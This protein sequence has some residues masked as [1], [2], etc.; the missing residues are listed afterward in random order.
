MASYLWIKYADYVYNKWERRIVW[1]M[2]KRY[3]RPK[4]FNPLL[5]IY[6]AAF[7]TGLMSAAITEQLYN[8]LSTNFLGFFRN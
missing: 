2:L 3:R 1:L 5:T 4:S 6:I 7:Y 8:F